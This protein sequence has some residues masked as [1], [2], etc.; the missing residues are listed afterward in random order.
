MILAAAAALVLSAACTKSEITSSLN[1]EPQAIG[2]TNYA[3]R[4]L[5][6][7]NDTHVTGGT[8]VAGKQ[9]AVY[10]WQ[11]AYNSFLAVDPGTP[12]F[13]NPAVVTWADNNAEGANNEYT[14]K[15]FWPSGDEP[16]NLS[17]TAYYP[18]GGAS[19]TAP[20]FTT[21]V[22][23]YAFAAQSTSAAMEDFCVAD[24]VNDQV[25]GNTNVTNA[26]ANKGTVNFTFKHQLTK[27]QF[28]FKKATGLG[29]TTVIELVDAKLQNIKTN[30]TLTATFTKNASEGVNK[31][32][33][34]STAW[35]ARAKADTPITYDVTLNQANPESGSVVVLSETASTIH[36][37][38]IFLMVPQ[39]MVAAG[40]TDE[41]SG[42]TCV[43][44]DEQKLVLTWNVKVYADDASATANASNSVG[45][46]GLLSMTTNTKTLSLKS[47]IKD[48][49][50]DPTTINWVKNHFVTYSI[51]VGP[52]PI[53]FTATVASWENEEHGYMSVQ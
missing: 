23:T 52:K 25:Y 15:R 48:D 29:T 35:S 45:T 6:K 24:V 39:T 41:D 53:L 17:F 3:P 10:A 49:Q 19:I 32:G 22:G 7:A 27:V 26:G 20:T 31:L 14:P 38:D 36:R 43:A 47:D 46:G 51:T 37:D 44:A 8:L 30:G 13:M 42:A 28:E 5:S 4:S 1:D 21:G 33:T 34:T 2:F 50:A 12:G 16:A 9:F 40:D 18:Y 11:T